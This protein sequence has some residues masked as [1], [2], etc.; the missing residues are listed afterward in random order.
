SHLKADLRLWT[1]KKTKIKIGYH[2]GVKNHLGGV[3]AGALFTLGEMCAGL[4][5]LKN[6]NPLK[7]RLILQSAS[8]EYSK[9]GRTAVEGASELSAEKLKRVRAA[10]KSKKQ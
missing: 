8:V 4:L 5:L 6:F 1:D 2:R 9:Q 3:H 7:F 10:I